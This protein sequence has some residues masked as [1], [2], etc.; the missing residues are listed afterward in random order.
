[1]SSCNQIIKYGIFTSHHVCHKSYDCH[2]KIFFVAFSNSFFFQDT[3]RYFGPIGNQ[4]WS[5]IIVTNLK[6][7]L[8]LM[9]CAT[10]L[11]IDWVH[12][13]EIFC[14]FTFSTIP[15]Y[16]IYNETWCKSTSIYDFRW[17]PCSNSGMNF[18]FNGWSRQF[19]L[20]PH[21][22]RLKWDQKIMSSSH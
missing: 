22:F 3:I 16:V 20:K 17:I 8:W 1:M 14:V 15:Y 10:S 13:F 18:I 19:K 6:K 9:I 4:F 11:I 5:K 7:K 2:R 21:E 12:V